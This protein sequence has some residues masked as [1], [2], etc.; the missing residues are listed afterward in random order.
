MD[1]A[2]IVADHYEVCAGAVMRVKFCACGI[3]WDVAPLAAYIT[4]RPQNMKF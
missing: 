1:A 2:V 4:I 3:F